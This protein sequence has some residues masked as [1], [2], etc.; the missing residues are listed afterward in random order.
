MLLKAFYTVTGHSVLNEQVLGKETRFIRNLHLSGNFYYQTKLQTV[1][2]DNYCLCEFKSSPHHFF[3]LGKN[4]RKESPKLGGLVK[5]RSIH[6]TGQVQLAIIT[7]HS[8][9]KARV[10]P[11]RRQQVLWQLLDFHQPAFESLLQSSRT[12]YS[13]Y[14]IGVEVRKHIL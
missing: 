11:H 6:E 7:L 10:M 1:N 12:A 4:K 3:I 2:L 9:E 5:T 14:A 8:S 13:S